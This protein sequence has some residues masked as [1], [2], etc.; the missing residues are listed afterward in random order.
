MRLEQFQQ[1]LELSKTGSFSQTARNLFLSQPNLSHSIKQL[2][3]E[4]GQP[5]FTRTPGGI[6]L[7]PF[8]VNFLSHIEL[9]CREYAQLQEFCNNPSVNQRLSLR[10]ATLNLNSITDP[11][12]KLVKKYMQTPVNFNLLNFLSM[13]QIVSQITMC[14]S[15]LA[16][17]GILSPYVKNTKALLGNNNI[18]YHKLYCSN[19]YAVVGPQNPLYRQE[20]PIDQEDLYPYTLIT[21]CQNYED[22]SFALARAIGLAERVVSNIYVN[23]NG[24]LVKTIRETQAVGLIANKTAAFAKNAAQLKILPIADCPLHAEIGWIKL[25]RLPLTDIMAEL[26]NLVESS[27]D[28]EN[29]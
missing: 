8:G 20:K 17:I 2:E 16:F 1:V 23:T 13:E 7:T 11:F 5:I 22:P 12:M 3:E 27:V 28:S 14:K 6:I 15:D 4:L 10:V 26:L 9:L 24:M 21:Y 19:I 29:L 25:R 18:E